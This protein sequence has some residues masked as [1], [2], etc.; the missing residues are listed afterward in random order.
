MQEA[1]L[2]DKEALMDSIAYCGLVSSN[3]VCGT[4]AGVFISDIT[5]TTTVKVAKRRS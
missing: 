5:E 3:A 4:K 2:L 1:H